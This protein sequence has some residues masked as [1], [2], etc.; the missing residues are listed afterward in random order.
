MA[1]D[2]QRRL[3]MIDKRFDLMTSHLRE[4]QENAKEGGPG[5]TRWG[6]GGGGQ[7]KGETVWQSS[8]S[9]SGDEGYGTGT[10]VV[11][12]GNLDRASLTKTDVKQF[13]KDNIENVTDG[14]VTK[15]TVDSVDVQ[16]WSEMG[17]QSISIDFDVYYGEGEDDED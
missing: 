10:A 6:D 12:T 8:F 11:S 9:K 5:S 4:S 14:K 15:D 1:N 13:L 3:D 7:L 2:I 17:T 16:G